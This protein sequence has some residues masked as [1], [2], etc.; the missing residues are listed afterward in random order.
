M[1]R[2]WGVL[3]EAFQK[4][5]PLNLILSLSDPNLRRENNE[6]RINISSRLER[7]R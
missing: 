5:N 2:L 7:R 1:N 6:R 3:K 4:R